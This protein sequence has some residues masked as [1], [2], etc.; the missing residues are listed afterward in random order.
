MTQQHRQLGS[1]AR[2]DEPHRRRRR[3]HA[4]ARDL[5]PRVPVAAGRGH[6]PP[7]AAIGVPSAGPPAALRPRGIRLAGRDACGSRGSS[8][9]GA[10][11]PTSTSTPRPIAHAA[12]APRA[13]ARRQALAAPPP[14]GD[15]RHAGR[16]RAAR[17]GTSTRPIRRPAGQ[18]ARMSTRSPRNGT[19][20]AS[21]SRRWRPPFASDRPR[22]R[23]AATA[24]S[25]RRNPKHRAGAARR[26]GAEVAVG[27]HA[28]ARDRAHAGEDRLVVD[29][30]RRQF[31]R[32]ETGYGAGPPSTVDRLDPPHEDRGHHR[33][34][35]SR[36]RDARADGRCGHGRRA[37][38]LLARRR[39]AARRA[40]RR[41]RDAAGRVV[42]AVAILQDLPG[43]K[44]RIGPLVDDIAEL[45]PGD[46][47]TF[48][49][50]ENGTGTAERMSVGRPE[51]CAA[52]ARGDVMYLA[53]GAVRLRVTPSAR[54]SWRSTPRS[55]SAA[56]W[57]R[58]RG[59][60]FRVRWSRSRPCPR[61][62]SHT[63]ASARRWRRHD[64]AAF[65][66]SAQDI[67]LVRDT[68]ACR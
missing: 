19:S 40:A 68:R 10:A 7:P 34:S 29:G 25:R 64:R 33:P 56:P 57:P 51:L 55:R 22:A 41:V 45:K 60:T 5:G 32:P 18:A 8:R 47:V 49:C 52:M 61:R 63:C 21:S 46:H 39:R 12:R 15:A 27:R 6:Q 67:Q 30:S 3:R 28:A 23:R 43:P 65:V 66:R 24:P 13:A 37:A 48:A 35:L 54:A 42:R 14:R 2:D 36:P 17:G 4:V 44:M 58:A 1:L 31:H 62:I 9:P 11:R 38:E 59:S 20:S 16:A 50:G 53:D 26:A